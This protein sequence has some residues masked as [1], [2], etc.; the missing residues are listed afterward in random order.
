MEVIK[1]IFIIGAPR[2][3][4]TL[5]YDTLGR[6]KALC[7]I[8]G[9]LMEAGIYRKGR[10]LGDNKWIWFKI[11]NALHR[12]ENDN[13]PN[14]ATPFWDR[15]LG[16]YDYLTEKDSNAEVA[17]YYRGRIAA[18]QGILRKHRFINKNP[19]HSLRVRLLDGIFPDAKFVHII[20]DGRAVAYS[21]LIK[22]IKEPNGTYFRS[23]NKIIGDKYAPDR[24]EL[25]NYGLAW[26]V[27]IKRARE[28]R[29]FGPTRYYEI[30][31]ENLVSQPYEQLRKIIVFCE[32]DWN[33]EFT[34]KI[35]PIGNENVKW[36]Q[37]L[38]EQEKYDVEESTRSLRSALNYA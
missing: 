19:Q 3:G 6:H 37:E 24:S 13:R 16:T 21:T 30:R 5:V 20:R 12:K 27:L 7:F 23:L 31:Y 25:Y 22:G 33:D 10:F 34:S 9:N 32:L 11:K 17:E 29:N 4:T 38:S 14:E 26:A 36:K 8:T 18:V 1:P 2:S 28:A 35:P 15:Y